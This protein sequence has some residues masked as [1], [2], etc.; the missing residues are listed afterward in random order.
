MKVVTFGSIKGGT[1]KSSI[2]LL[3]ERALAKSGYKCLAIDLDTNNSTSSALKPKDLKE[4][5][6]T[7]SKNIASALLSDDKDISNC[8]IH[9]NYPN[10]DIIRNH[11]KITR[12][13][14][15]LRLLKNKIEGSNFSDKYSFIFI[16]TPACYYDLHAMAYEASDLI[17]SPVNPVKFDLIPLVQLGSNI[18]EDTTDSAKNWHLFFNK[19]KPDSAVQDEYFNLFSQKF[20]ER[21]YDVKVPD[22]QKVRQCIDRKI[23]VGK[24]QDYLK[25]RSS[26]CKLASEIAGVEINPEENF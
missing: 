9:S 13:K 17:I 15:S 6:V 26:I 21:I 23:L 4:Q 3:V 18:T 19:V 1:G 16:D 12:V 14:F 2:Q 22:T 8:I 25:L 24:S 5:D 10:I 11:V 7:G 20:P